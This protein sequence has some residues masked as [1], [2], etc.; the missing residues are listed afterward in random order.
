[1]KIKKKKKMK[2][3]KKMKYKKAFHLST[4]ELAAEEKII[5]FRY[6]SWTIQTIS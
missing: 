4:E 3:K 6:P 1:M 2:M 5:Y